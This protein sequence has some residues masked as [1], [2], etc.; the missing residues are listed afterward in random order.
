M[1]KH[2]SPYKGKRVDLYKKPPASL[3]K[4]LRQ[5]ATPS[6]TG[7]YHQHERSIGSIWP[8]SLHM[9]TAFWVEYLFL[10]LNIFPLQ[11]L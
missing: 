9:N 2:Y 4:I 8:F 3:N 7:Q 11:P 5:R 10:Y 6:L 1:N